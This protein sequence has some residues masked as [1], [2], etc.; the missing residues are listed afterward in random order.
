MVCKL[1][2]AEEGC[3]ASGV[4]V[5]GQGIGEDDGGV[6]GESLSILPTHEEH[7]NCP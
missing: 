2:L 3:A 6:E 1:E 7:R 4:S 5:S